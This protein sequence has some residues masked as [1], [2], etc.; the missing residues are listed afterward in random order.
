MDKI[1]EILTGP[2]ASPIVLSVLTAIIGYV[3]KTAFVKKYELE[4]CILAL[5][6][7]V[8][9]VYETYV[10]SIKAASEDG[11]LTD[12]EKDEARDKA[13]THAKQIL[14]TEGIDL[15]KYYGPRIAKAVIEKL[16]KR[17]KTAGL[18]AKGVLNVDDTGN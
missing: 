6:S 18:M 14:A 5:E 4:R 1:I 17:S 13:Y 16:I 8:Q 10:K 7:G 3:L 15:A 2:A 11:K 12:M 9:E